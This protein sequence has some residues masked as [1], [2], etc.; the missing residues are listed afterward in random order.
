AVGGESPA[1]VRIPHSPPSVF[2]YFDFIGIELR[3]DGSVWF[4]FELIHNLSI[5]FYT[6]V[7]KQIDKNHFY[8]GISNNLK[9]R[10]EQHNNGENISTKGNAWEIYCYFAFPKRKIAENF[11]KYLKTSSGRS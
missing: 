6:C 2:T 1:R 11:E 8:T 4:D 9:R 3:R 10:L 7:L 5:M